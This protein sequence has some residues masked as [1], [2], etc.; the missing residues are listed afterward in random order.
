M[1]SA[2]CTS[3]EDGVQSRKIVSHFGHV[4]ICP[5]AYPPVGVISDLVR[6][7]ILSTAEKRVQPSRIGPNGIRIL[8][9]TASK[10]T[11]EE[12]NLRLERVLR[13]ACDRAEETQPH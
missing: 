3:R 4:M 5:R 9:L 12:C 1:S 10:F 8:L 6:I 11:P 2:V 13:F 7:H